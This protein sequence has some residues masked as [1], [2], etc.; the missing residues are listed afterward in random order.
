MGASGPSPIIRCRTSW[1]A[2][3]TYAPHWNRETGTP[4]HIWCMHH[5]KHQPRGF[6]SHDVGAPRRIW[7]PYD[8]PH[9]LCGFD[10]CFETPPPPV[11]RF[12]SKPFLETFHSIPSFSGQ[13][14]STFAV[15]SVSYWNLA[16]PPG[17]ANLRSSV[18]QVAV[19]SFLT[20]SYTH[21]RAHET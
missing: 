2:P 11:A 4:Q 20:V 6:A 8:T 7:C 3:I 18:K 5:M 1:P 15:T 17:N 14:R 21:L 19:F 12:D 13:R 9:Q 16:P 10:S